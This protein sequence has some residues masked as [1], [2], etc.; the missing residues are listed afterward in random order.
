[1]SLVK[2]IMLLV[3]GILVASVAGLYATSL[4]GWSALTFAAVC[5]AVV[6]VAVVISALMSLSRGVNDLQKRSLDV[7]GYE[8][9]ISRRVAQLSAQVEQLKTTQHVP[10]ENAALSSRVDHLQTEITQLRRM[11]IAQY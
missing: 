4:L 9:D 7:G 3:G 8:S 6:F 5:A 10:H 2:R 11:L 1:M